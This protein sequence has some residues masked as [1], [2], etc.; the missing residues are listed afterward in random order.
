MDTS[1]SVRRAVIGAVTAL[2]VL[3][4][5][6]L[7]G[8]TAT[9]DSH[10]P[11]AADP[12]AIRDW[13]VI[14]TD[15]ISANLGPTRPSG[16][17][18]IWHGFVSAAVYNAVVGIQRT[19]AP[20]KWR[21]RGP[22]TASPEAA[23]VT[24]AHRV[25]VT[26]FPASQASLDAAY[27]GS[28]AKIP[29]GRAKRQGVAFGERAAGHL[30]ALREDDGRFAPVEFTAAPA[31]GVWRPT[32]PAH[33]PFIDPWLAVLRPLLLTSPAQFRPGGPPALSSARYARDVNEV[34][35]M[36]AKTGS[37]RT[38]QQTATALFFG[39]NLAAQFQA[40]F[41]DHTARHHLDIAD[42]AR[43]FAAANASATDAVV[44]AWDAK[45]HYGFWRPITAIQLADTDGN[46]A[47]DADP[48][49]QPL[50][51]TPPHPD[52]LSGHTTVAG[53][54]TRTLTGILGTTH[55]D[56]NVPSE[57]TGTTRHYDEADQLNEDMINARV[58]A[59]IHFR[60]ADVVG[61]QTGSRIGVWA[62]THYFRPLRSAGLHAVPPA[63]PNCPSD[64][65]S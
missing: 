46:P 13:N 48:Q 62:L 60:T 64:S 54:V 57:I 32:P 59:G 47:T 63:R 53:A 49:W 27:A 3:A 5:T 17:V 18:V 25:L 19:Y 34:K 50:L 37:A 11:P 56:L 10:R 16:Q 4:L 31:P 26:Y 43:L 39:G 23:A 38:A 44:T 36:G 2:L 40:A 6:A 14:A 45:L 58:W 22:V 52:Y 9:A 7:A 55:L 8:P 1:R 35:T 20:Y 42:T 12:A 28:L 65:A 30:I 21:A 41:R 15:T 24:A 33:Q 29:D 51:V 61:C